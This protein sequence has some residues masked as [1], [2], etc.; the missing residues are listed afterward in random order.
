M[1]NLYASK[2]IK[3]DGFLPGTTG[4][5][6]ICLKNVLLMDIYNMDRHKCRQEW[7]LTVV[8]HLNPQCLRTIGGHQVV[9]NLLRYGGTFHA[10]CNYK[11][12][13]WDFVCG[14]QCAKFGLLLIDKGGT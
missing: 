6:C 10:F 14:F 5:C 4:G 7:L 13:Q 11:F 8:L 3:V 2:L 9:G 12:L 1:I